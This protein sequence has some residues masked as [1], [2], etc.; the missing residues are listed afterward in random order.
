ME[1]PRCRLCGDRHYGLCPGLD[2][3]KKALAEKTSPVLP[4][5]PIEERRAGPVVETVDRQADSDPPL[6][7]PD[8]VRQ[9]PV[10]EE[11]IEIRL[12]E[13]KAEVQVLQARLRK[14]RQRERMRKQRLKNK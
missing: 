3:F 2:P 6:V 13:L 11:E 14:L 10:L 8:V 12:D 1:A 4:L 5:T 7:V 9:A